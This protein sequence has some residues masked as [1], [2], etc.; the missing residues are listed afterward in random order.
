MY[1]SAKKFSAKIVFGFSF[2]FL[3]F[4]AHEAYAASLSL[5]PSSGSYNVGD[6]FSVRI[7]LSS[8]DQS[9]NAVA[10]NIAFSKNL[11]TLTSISKTNSLVNIWA[12]EPSY[13]N[14]NGTADME[15]VILNGYTGSN[16]TIITFYFK[17]KA[18][19]NANIRFASSSVLA[20]DGQGTNIIKS[21]GQANFSISPLK[22]KVATEEPIVQ[23]QVSTPVFTDYS[24]DI[25]EGE[26]LVVKGLADPNTEI[27]INSDAV[28][29]STQEVAHVLAVVKSDEKGAFTYVSEKARSGTYMITAQAHYPD[30]VFSEKTL[31]IKISVSPLLSTLIPNNIMGL[32]SIIIPILALI[33]LLILLMIW[34]WHHIL[35]YREYMQKKLI[36]ARNVVSKSFNILDEDVKE[37]VKIF[38]KIKALESLS[39]EDRLFINQF[40]KDIEAAEKVILNKIKE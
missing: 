3:L 31:P 15:G 14:V 27:F 5:S 32:L 18:A 16:G 6:A 19:G 13:S 26:F 24:K 12:L 1:P 21:S 4:F 38:K 22:E 37:E 36:E 28:L 7:I 9:A 29:S 34:G 2:I 39:N 17:A 30:G 35:H 8:T 20:N 23:T 33:I 11:L 10:A 40:K 25:H